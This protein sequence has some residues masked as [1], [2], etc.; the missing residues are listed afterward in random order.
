MAASPIGQVSIPALFLDRCRRTP[1]RVAA[2]V[3]E[4]GLYRE[5]TWSEYR[6]H[7][8]RVCLGLV[9]AGLQAGDR[10]AIMADPSIE[11]CYVDLGAQAAGVVTYGI[12][13]TS[14]ASHVRFAREDGRA[15]IGAAS[16]RE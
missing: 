2:R 3:K 6:G 7:V 8:E 11:W 13:S 15:M 9:E 5:I 4:Y 16:A 10:V 1:R 12:Y 14:S